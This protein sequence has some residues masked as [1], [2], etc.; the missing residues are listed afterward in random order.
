MAMF[1][2]VLG[3]FVPWTVRMVDYSFHRLLP[4]CY[5]GGNLRHPVSCSIQQS[6]TEDSCRPAIID[7]CQKQLS[8]ISFHKFA[9]DL[10]SISVAND[11]DKLEL[12]LQNTLDQMAQWADKWD[13]S[14]NTSKTK[15]Y[16]VW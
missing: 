5:C 16:V 8:Q 2:A 1:T 4:R 12:C 14:L 9:D 13:M 7:F 3:L 15:V 11:I 6:Y 10:A